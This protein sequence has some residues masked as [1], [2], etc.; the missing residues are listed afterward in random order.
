MSRR[1]RGVSRNGTEGSPSLPPGV[2]ASTIDVTVIVII[3]LRLAMLTLT[4]SYV[5][6]GVVINL[7]VVE[8]AGDGVDELVAE[9]VDGAVNDGK[10]T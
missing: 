5:R 4:A 8:H 1:W 7:A 2:T 6:R 9:V 10:S 3:T